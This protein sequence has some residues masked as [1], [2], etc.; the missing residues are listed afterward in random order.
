MRSASLAAL[1]AILVL[2]ACSQAEPEV[3]L[4]LPPVPDERLA[5]PPLLPAEVEIAERAA[6]T[7]DELLLQASRGSLKGLAALA[8]RNPDFKSNLGGQD[9]QQFWDLLR[10]TGVD[11]NRKLR[12]LFDQPAGL[13][14]IDGERW[15]VWPD[16]AAKDAADLIPEK[17]TFQERRRLEELIGDEGI[18]RIRAGEGYP[19]MRTAISEDGVWIYFVLGQDG[20][21]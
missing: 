18:E 12:D 3:V 5:Q 15:Y 19:G 4:P 7:R 9:H 16:L 13:R 21:E 6:R 11:P 20:E 10:R 8:A 2:A 1:M 17:L 14:E